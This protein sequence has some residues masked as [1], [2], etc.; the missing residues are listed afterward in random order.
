M[1]FKNLLSK[2]DTFGTINE[3]TERPGQA[4]KMEREKSRTSDFKARDAARKRVE[5]SRAIPRDKKSK[6]DLLKE[7]LL[8][9]T[10]SGRLQLIFK[11]SYNASYHD[12]VSGK[13]LTLGEAQQAAKDSS[14]EQTRASKLL[15]GEVKEKED[16]KEKKK[17]DTEEKDRKEAKPKSGEERRKAKRLSQQE[18]FQSMAQMGPEQLMNVPPDIRIEYFKMSRKPPANNDFDRVSYEGLSAQYGLSNVSSAPYNQQVLNAIMFLAKLKVGA[19][20]QEIQTFMAL[21]PDVREFTKSAFFTAKKILSQIGDQCLQNLVTNLE[22]T[23][24]PINSEGMPD[25]ECGNYKFKIAAGGE[26][27]MSSTQFDQSNKNFK[28]FVATA[29]TQALSNPELISSNQTLSAAFQKMQQGKEAFS[30]VLIQDELLPQIMQ[31]PKLVKQLQQMEIKNPDGQVIGTVLDEEGN[32]NQLASVNYYTKAWEEGAKEIIKGAGKNSLKTATINGMLKIILRGDGLVDPN[33]APNHLI[34]VNGILPLSDQYFNTISTQ[35]TLDINPSK[36]VMTSSNISNYKPSAAE[37]LKKFTTVV[38]AKQTV[39]P[40]EGAMVDKD[41]IEPISI[42]VDYIVRNHDFLMNASLLPGFKSK[43]LNSV[44]YNYVTIGKK[45]I[46]IPVMKGENIT[47]EVLGESA[48]FLNDIL[49]EGIT[50]NFV[51]SSLVRNSLIT[52][53]EA[54]LIVSS[55]GV[56]NEDSEYFEINLRTILENAVARMYQGPQTLLGLIDDFVIEEYKRDYKKEYKNYHGKKKQRKERSART[57][58]RELMKK[59]GLVKKGDGKDV[60]HKK[61]LRNGGSK[62][63]N[64]LRVRDKSENRSDNGHHKGEKQNKDWK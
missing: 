5:R 43:D 35:S 52:E 23:G 47:N 60:D 36:D 2:I 56:L 61:P 38:E 3:A 58:A 41:S 6:Q 54:E 32:L 62:S 27:S 19:S 63:L 49:I 9:K 46:K 15:F 14:F 30:Q 7:V 33:M 10:K 12:K 4:E 26:I 42:M 11:D 37:M 22:T 34:T 8:V 13:E 20:E 17:Q 29:L 28:K 16:R 57:I 21:A 48:L 53:L 51:L 44:Q 40:L 50:N 18:M 31:D 45:T 24:K 55:R 64:N 25:M 1:N 39:N 59:K